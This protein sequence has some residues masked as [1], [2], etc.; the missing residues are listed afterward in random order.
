MALPRIFDI[1]GS[2]DFEKIYRRFS[3][4]QP[5]SM[6][7]PRKKPHTTPSII[8]SDLDHRYSPSESESSA[9]ESDGSVQLESTRSATP[10]PVIPRKRAKQ[11]K[12]PRAPALA[13]V[14]VLVPVPVPDV[15]APTI[16]YA[17]SVFSAAEMKKAVSKRVPKSSS[18]QLRTDEPWDTTKAQLLVK[19]SDALGAGA[20]LDFSKYNIMIAILRVITKP[21]QPLTSEA[22][23]T[24]LLH[25]I[26]SAKV[27]DPILANVTLTQLE[28]PNDKENEATVDEKSKK[29]AAKDPNNL[30]GNL[31]K[32]AKIAQLEKRWPCNQK[33]ESCEGTFCYVDHE[34]NHLPLS[35]G[36]LDCWASSIV[37]FRVFQLESHSPL[38]QMRGEEFATIDRPPNHP[39]FDDNSKL[40]PV[41]RK[42]LENSKNVNA[43][44]GPTINFS[45]GK[46]LV[47]LLRPAAPV[48]AAQ[49]IAPP[50]VY[51][52]PRSHNEYDLE[53]PTILQINRKQ[54]LDMTLDLFC[55]EYDLDDGIRD[56]FRENRYKHARMFR[57]LTIKD[58]ETMKF[59]AGEIA[60]VR[61]AIDRWSVVA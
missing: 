18:F 35:H 26:S 54:G 48:V 42:R 38:S 44:A 61:D 21:G 45:I 11:A 29:K 39:L 47:D 15:V 13:P 30:P 22:D 2:R 49:P 6:P 33:Q 7:G 3:H 27:K 31:N 28:Q 53:C 1:L 24:L 20:S 58:L 14:P 5:S 10:A 51:T 59:W 9:H 17:V 60:E 25:R 34:G 8:T 4:P 19:I 52:A 56:R 23:Y 55:A 32:L 41:L 43:V 46:E 40:S 16:N 37:S 50:P 57:F 36:R 12:Q